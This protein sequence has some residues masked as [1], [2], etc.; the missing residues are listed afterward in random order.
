MFVATPLLVGLV[1]GGRISSASLD[2][3]VAVAAAFLL[4]QPVTVAVKILAGRRARG[5]LPAAALWTA[6]YGCL[7][8]WGA[9]RL[10]RGGHGELLWLAPPAFAIL[11]WYLALVARRGERDRPGLQILGTGA[12]ALAAP[13]ALWIAR[14]EADPRGWLLWALLWSQAAT[15]ILHVRLRLRQRRW[16]RVPALGRRLRSAAP[17]LAAAAGQLAAVMVLAAA[18]WVPPLLGVAYGIQAAESAV[19][20]VRPAVGE[21]PTAVGLRQLAVSAAFTICFL[22]AW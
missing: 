18:G 8:A 7:A 22:L 4:R 16:A 11:G 6:V 13:A 21:R 20:A 1:A 15:S 10:L 9:I 19:G 17:S 12:L 14:G 2:L 5:D 3:V